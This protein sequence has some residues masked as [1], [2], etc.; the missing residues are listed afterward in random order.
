MIRDTPSIEPLGYF[1]GSFV[2]MDQMT[3]SLAH[4]AVTFGLSTYTVLCAIRDGQNQGLYIIRLGDHYRRL[5]DSCSILGFD[6]LAG[7]CSESEFEAILKELLLRNNVDQDVFIRMMVMVNAD[8]FAPSALQQPLALAAYIYRAWPRPKSG[9]TLGVSSW[10]RSSDN[11]IPPRAKIQGSYTNA[12]LVRD[13]AQRHG[14]D[15]GIY[16]DNLGRVAEVSN[17]NLC[18]VRDGNVVSPPPYDDLVEGVTVRAIGD[19][20]ESLN[21]GLCW[22]PISRTELYVCDEAFLP[23]AI[24]GLISISHIDD[25]EIGPGQDKPITKTLDEAYISAIRSGRLDNRGWLTPVFEA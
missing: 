1:N 22:R 23:A 12:A 15:D 6:P 4:P 14:Y 10:R 16:L 18:I 25:R 13:E 2:P 3:I 21:I 11:A 17:K 19:L 8:L 5:R 7:L 20:A 24:D 9:I